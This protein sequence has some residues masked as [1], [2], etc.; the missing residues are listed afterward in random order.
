MKESQAQRQA[1]IMDYQANF[2]ALHKSDNETQN[3]ML[4]PTEFIARTKKDKADEAKIKR[5]LNN[6]LSNDKDEN[7]ILLNNT[8]QEIKRTINNKSIFIKVIIAGFLSILI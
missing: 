7:E 4:D 1:K 8:K 5:F 6:D 3:H 2:D